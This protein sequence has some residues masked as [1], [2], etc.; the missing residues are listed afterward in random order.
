[1]HDELNWRKILEDHGAAQSKADW[2]NATL[3]QHYFSGVFFQLITK[4]RNTSSLTL[5]ASFSNVFAHSFCLRSECSNPYRLSWT[6]VSYLWW[7]ESQRDH[8]VFI[9]L[10]SLLLSESFFAACILVSI[11]FF[12]S[13]LNRNAFVPTVFV[14]YVT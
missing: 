5:S 7:S 10:Y 11:F 9:L 4:H 14:S 2:S 3:S 8:S 12:L 13:S 6:N 1:M